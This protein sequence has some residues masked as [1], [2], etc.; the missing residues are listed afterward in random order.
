M[1]SEYLTILNMLCQAV[2]KRFYHVVLKNVCREDATLPTL[3][4]TLLP[5]RDLGR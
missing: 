3:R 2:A 4:P 5:K 1:P